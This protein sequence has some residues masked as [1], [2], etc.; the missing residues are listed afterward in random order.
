MLA[1]SMTFSFLGGS[2][3]YAQVKRDVAPLTYGILLDHSQSMKD[4][5]K[6]IT[7]AAETIINA[8]STTDETFIVQFVSSDKIDTLQELTSDRMKLLNSVN[9][10]RTEAGATAIIDAVYLS[11]QYLSQKS[12]NLKAH[13]GLVLIT[14]G[15]ERASFYKLNALLALLRQHQIPVYIL[16]YV[17]GVKKDDAYRYDKAKKFINRL[18]LESG[19]KVILAE[20]PKEIE[21]KAAD[22][23]RLLRRE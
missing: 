7:A 19:G 3:Q 1:A 18:A 14:D 5:L 11:A 13:Y 22:I 6:Y 10:L 20:K 23:A 2:R 21:E 8:N 17:N 15:D 12:S 9:G 16:A 4:N